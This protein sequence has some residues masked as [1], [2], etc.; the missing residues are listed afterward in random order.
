MEN[1]VGQIIWQ[2]MKTLDMN[3]VWCMGV[4]KPRALQNGLRF[5]VN[6][7]SFKGDVVITLNGKDLYD[8][9][10]IKVSR[11]VNKEM[12]DLGVKIFNTT[13]T[14]LE[15][16]NDVYAEDMMQVLE[17]KVEKRG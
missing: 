8:I 9:S 1:Q 2:Q 10:F 11:K 16:I 14:L 3:L 15:T 12:K 7:L 4:Q 6:G 5:S 13:E 17:L